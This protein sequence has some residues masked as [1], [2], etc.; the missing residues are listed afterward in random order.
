L[1]KREAGQKS[2]VPFKSICVSRN[3]AFEQSFVSL[4]DNR[5]HLIIWKNRS[6]EH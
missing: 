1:N 3:N 6:L 2:C 5:N 4:V